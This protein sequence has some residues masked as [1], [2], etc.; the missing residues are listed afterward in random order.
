MPSCPLPVGGHRCS[1]LAGLLFVVASLAAAVAV[2]WLLRGTAPLDTRFP[3]NDRLAFLLEHAADFDLVFV[4][5]SRIYR[6]IVPAEFDARLAEHGLSVR[7]FNL[8]MPGMRAFEADLA[9]R[10]LVREAGHH[11]K[12]VVIGPGDFSPKILDWEKGT[13]RTTAWHTG[14]QTA[15]VLGSTWELELPASERADLARRH[16]GYFL[17]REANHGEGARMLVS[18]IGDSRLTEAEETLIRRDAGFQGLDGLTN[19]VIVDRRRRFEAGRAAFSRQ[20]E[21]NAARRR[22]FAAPVRRSLATLVRLGQAVRSG[23]PE[24]VL[25]YG[26]GRG[27]YAR[28]TAEQAGGLPFLSF[29]DPSRYPELFDPDLR[30]DSSHLSRA[31]ASVYTRLLA[32]AM[33]PVLAAQEEAAGAL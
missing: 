11:L 14:S 21:R 33:V 32:D 23:G 31:G 18:W 26:P 28:V 22:G 24:P 9:V 8:G 1:W 25:L 3:D 27:H 30:F 10:Y 2:A 20:V 29:D 12:T 17:R 19:P 16:L 6:G 13:R 4:G 5:N 15:A 7:S